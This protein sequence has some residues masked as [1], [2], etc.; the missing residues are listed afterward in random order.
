MGREGY[1]LFINLLSTVSTVINNKQ[2]NALSQF[3]NEKLLIS[4]FPFPSKIVLPF[5]IHQFFLSRCINSILLQ[6][7]FYNNN[8]TL[9]MQT[10]F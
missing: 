6:Y 2:H 9:I 3:E 4:S 1:L 8:I 10:L 7:K 5:F